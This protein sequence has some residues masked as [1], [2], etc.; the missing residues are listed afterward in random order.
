M[1]R[2]CLNARLINNNNSQFECCYT[3]NCWTIFSISRNWNRWKCFSDFPHLKTPTTFMEMPCNL[4]FLAHH[5]AICSDKNC[6]V[7]VFDVK[8]TIAARSFV[9]SYERRKL[10]Y[11]NSFN[12]AMKLEWNKIGRVNT[13][14]LFVDFTFMLDFPLNGNFYRDSSAFMQQQACLWQDCALQ[15]LCNFKEFLVELCT[16]MTIYDKIATIKT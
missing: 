1:S 10:I 12:C 6:L 14:R 5:Q 4:Q 15:K 8:S 2:R 13:C 11:N 9:V 16:K 3:F 7:H